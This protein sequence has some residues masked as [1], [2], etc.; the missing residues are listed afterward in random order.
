MKILQSDFE[1]ERKQLLQQS[2]NFKQLLEERTELYVNDKQ[3]LSN[4]FSEN[5]KKLIEDA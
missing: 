4:K 1:I 3:T 5:Q 2:N